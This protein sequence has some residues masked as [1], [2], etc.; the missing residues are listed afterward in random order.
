MGFWHGAAWNFVLWGLYFG[1]LLIAEKF[2]LLKRMDKW[3]AVVRHGYTLFFVVISWV[4]FY[5]EDFT[6][7]KS[8]LQGM[9][10]LG[11]LPLI[12]NNALY[13]LCNYALLFLVAAYAATPHFKKKVISRLENTDRKPVF[14]A[15]SMG[16]IVVFLLC[17]S[18]L[19]S[20][21]YNP[22]LYFRF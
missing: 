6:Q 15:V 22:F 21:T 12:N 13:Y 16:Y 19:V 10:G 17:V 7:M 18:Y 3:P 4:I 20:S 9:F 5:F 1:L 8:Y 2:F 14:V 11:G